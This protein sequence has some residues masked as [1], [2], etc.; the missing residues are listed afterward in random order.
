MTFRSRAGPGARRAGR[1]AADGS[2][3]GEVFANGGRQRRPRDDRAGRRRDSI[4]S[5]HDGSGWRD[6]GDADPVIGLSSQ[7]TAR[8]LRP[9]AS[10]RSTIAQRVRDRTSGYRWAQ[11]PA[12]VKER[13]RRDGRLT[14]SRWPWAATHRAIQGLFPRP[15]AAT[16]ASEDSRAC[17]ARSIGSMGDPRG[18]D[19]GGHACD[20]EGLARR[21]RSAEMPGMHRD[22]RMGRQRGIHRGSVEGGADALTARRSDQPRAVAPSDG[23]RRRRTT[24]AV[25][26][27]NRLGGPYRVWAV[28]SAQHGV[29]VVVCAQPERSPSS[30]ARTRSGG[31][32]RGTS[33]VRRALPSGRTMVE[34]PGGASWRQHISRSG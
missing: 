2:L 24:N 14:P 33:R 13:T 19:G 28:G 29:A 34:S 31:I 9:V 21:G 22:R 23:S 11:G 15:A 12:A 16:R 32:D 27:P 20:C 7:E 4:R 25:G 18:I 17:I 8:L 26:S 30:Q 6:V 3:E 10:T 1:Q 5:D